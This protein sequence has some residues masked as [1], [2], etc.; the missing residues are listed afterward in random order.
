[1]TR[2]RRRYYRTI[3]L[4]VAA[5]GLL[6][7]SAMDQFGLSPQEMRSAFFTALLLIG[8]IVTV[9][10]VAAAVWVAFRALLRRLKP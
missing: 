9:G 1:M 6:V 3:F 4:G 5:M 8:T 10:A 7:W 2:A